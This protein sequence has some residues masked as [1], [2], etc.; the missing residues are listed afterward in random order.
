V[1]VVEVVTRMGGV[2]D[3]RT[4]VA[5][6]S[7]REVRLA[8]GRGE[9]VRDARGKYALPS[10][11]H[12]RRAANRLAAVITGASAAAAHGWELKVPPSRPTVTV[13]AKRRVDPR[14]RVGVDLHWRDIP[15]DHV[16]DG[17]LRPGPAVID[18]A[19]S[20]P[21]D[22][23][24]A[25]ADS[26]LRHRSVTRP[27]LLHL[28]EQVRTTGRARCLR[29]AREA[30]W[31]AANP[32]ES[33]LR[34]IAL[35]VPGLQMRPQVVISEGGWVGRPDLVDER[36]R[37]VVEAESFEFHGRR[38]ALRR[39]CERYT[40]LVLLGWTVIRFAW[41]HVMF[42]PAYV[43]ECLRLLPTAGDNRSQEQVTLPDARRL[44]A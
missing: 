28:A 35:D 21:L 37:L 30:S 32:F 24:L 43:A 3:A 33:V 38:T 1:Q 29:V 17:V 10:A 44:S 15:P 14:R 6:T 4:L 2:A 8:Q 31:L 20:M 22:E 26:A 16:W 9:V 27:E 42:A 12:A 7:A 40:A 25:V 41:E 18:C 13:P 34:A 36:R 39:D 11:D 19:K 5:F 23:A